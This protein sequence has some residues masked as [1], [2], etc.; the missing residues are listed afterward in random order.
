MNELHKDFLD[1]GPQQ[2]DGTVAEEAK[3][4]TTRDCRDMNVSTK[5]LAVLYE[6][7]S[8][9][10]QM[11]DVTYFTCGED[12]SIKCYTAA[13]EHIDV[14]ALLEKVMKLANLN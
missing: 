14:D 4:V 2:Y 3:E 11:A 12:L 5:E 10:N 13:S 8:F 7:L 1:F 9:T 6:A